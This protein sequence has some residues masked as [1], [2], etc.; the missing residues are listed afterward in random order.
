VLLGNTSQLTTVHGTLAETPTER[1]YLEDGVESFR[2]MARLS[3]TALQH[4]TTSQPASGQIEIITS[5]Q[6]SEDFF[7]GQQVQIY[8]VLSEPPLPL[9]EGLFD[10]RNYLR[11]QEIYYQLKAGSND[12]RSV[13]NKVPPSLNDRFARW[14]KSALAIGRPADSS[15]HLEQALTLGEKTFLTDDVTEPFVRASTYHIFAV[16]GLRMAILFGIF[17][18]A[19]RWLR[20]PRTPRGLLLIP[21]IWFYVDLTGWPASAIRAAI[22]LTVVIIG[23]LLKRPSNVL[24]SLFA[25]ALIIL[26]WQPQQLFQAGFQ[27]SFFVV[28]CILLVM[29]HF[30]NFVH[31]F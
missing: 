16:D 7:R 29:P 21:L 3:V 10:F 11:R 24:N 9:A 25:A 15:L 30:D 28:L 14:A 27:L 31:I 13:G 18:K 4:G 23:W 17:F 6:P 22:M 5:G 26:L 1:V 2:T 20:V 12:W 19:L 8:G